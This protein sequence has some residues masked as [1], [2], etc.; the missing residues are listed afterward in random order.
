MKLNKIIGIFLLS[1]TQIFAQDLGTTEVKV[2][3]GFKP[4]IPDASRLN[5]K[6]FFQDTTKKDRGQEYKVIN[7]DLKSD[8]KTKPLKAAKV[9]ADKIQQLYGTKVGVGFGNAWTTKA[10]ILHNSKRSR[11]FS[12]GVVANHF[13]NKYSVPHPYYEGVQPAIPKS[14]YQV[15]NSKNT[16]HLYGKKI[17]A[18]HIYVANL[19]YD[20]RTALYYSEGLVDLI[21]DKFF[22]NRFTY[23]KLSFSAISKETNKDKLRYNT[24]FFVSDLNELSEN[25]IH[26]SSNLSKKI[27]S[28]ES[29]LSIEYNNYSNYNN[30]DCSVDGI[31]VNSLSVSP[32][33]LLPKYGVDFDLGLSLRYVSDDSFNIFPQIKASK[34]LVKDVLM[35]YAGFRNKAQRHTLKSLADENPYIHSFGSNQ[36]ILAGNKVLQNLKTTNVNELFVAMKNKL[37]VEEFF[38]GSVAYGVVNNFTHFVSVVNGNYNRFLANYGD[39][40]QLHISANYDRKVNDIIGF[41]ATANYYNWDQDVYYKPKFK[42]ELRV[43]INLRDKI[44]VA[45]S[46]SYMGGRKALYENLMTYDLGLPFDLPA[47]FHANL[48]MHY[49]YSK[50]LSAYLMLN[51]LTN[52]RQEMWSGY[53]E[54][55]FNGVFGVNYSF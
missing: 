16:F 41:N 39:L 20:R 2:L 13:A 51:N 14:P 38:E 32:S 23:S 33:L 54:V 25:Q 22:R 1:V 49:N 45:P 8:Y 42:A 55:G 34:E 9:K 19:D 37:G 15:R 11:T 18:S 40:K 24:N 30:P 29:F 35:V 28:Y 27:K 3:E 5:K 6:A 47:Q 31:N 4:S 21:E 7:T 43:P 36:S 48:G 44:R 50:Q 46:L 53:Q 52:S 12:Y 17:S 26:L 10:S